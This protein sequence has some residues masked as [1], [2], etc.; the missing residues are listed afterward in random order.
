MYNLQYNV[1]LLRNVV[2]MSCSLQLINSIS[3][4]CQNFI[5]NAKQKGKCSIIPL[6]L[7]YKTHTV[8]YN[9]HKKKN[10]LKCTFNF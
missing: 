9:R 7:A 10:V 5:Q 4:Y 3:N 6:H 1:V 8:R 2:D